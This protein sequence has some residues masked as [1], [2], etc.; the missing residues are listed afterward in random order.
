M[1]LKGYALQE[2]INTEIVSA[3][4]AS[5][6]DVP[7]VVSAP[8]WYTIAEF[9]LPKTVRCCLEVIASVSAGGLIG[10]CR[11]YDPTSGVDAPVSGSDVSF[12]ATASDR[13]RSGAIELA[14]NRRYMIQC[15]CVG[16]LGVDKFATVQ[17]GCLGAV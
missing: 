2:E 10:T 13:Y 9:F 16:A 17:N 15:Q 4:A 1:S 3:Y 14:G 8:G 11:L 7:A 5:Q 6:A 12:S